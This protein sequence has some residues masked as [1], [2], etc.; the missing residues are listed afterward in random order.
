[1]LVANQKSDA[2]VVIRRD[3]ATGM[4]GETVQALQQA[5]PSDLKFID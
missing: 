4:L 5:A 3:P 1:M 2:I